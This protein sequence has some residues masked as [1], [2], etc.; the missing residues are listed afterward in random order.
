MTKTQLRRS[1]RYVRAWVAAHRPARA[2]GENPS[3]HAAL[4]YQRLFGED[5]DAFVDECGAQLDGAPVATAHRDFASFA[6]VLSEVRTSLASH[7]ASSAEASAFVGDGS[8]ARREDD[9]KRLEELLA[10]AT[11]TEAWGE[12]AAA[13][14]RNPFSV[15][16]K[17]VATMEEIDAKL[18]RLKQAGGA[19]EE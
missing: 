4:Q 18:S 17:D 16:D 8:P 12:G 2:R 1:S 13:P 9:A 5:L 15:D 3:F 7:A 11:S 14:A 19:E 6:A 10:E